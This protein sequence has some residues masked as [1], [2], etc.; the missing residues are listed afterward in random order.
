MAGFTIYGK[1]AGNYMI[2][3]VGNDDVKLA[4]SMQEDKSDP[5]AVITVAGLES[6]RDA[7]YDWI[8]V[9]ITYGIGTK[10]DEKDR[11]YMAFSFWLLNF[12]T[13]AVDYNMLMV[14]D[15]ASKGIEHAIRVLVATEDDYKGA[16]IYGM[17]EADL[18]R[19]E[20]VQTQGHYLYD[21]FINET[22]V[23]NRDV[24][25]LPKDGAVKYTVVIWLEGWDD[26]CIDDLWGSSIKMSLHITGR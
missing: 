21:D 17:P 18:S 13:R 3:V 9:D 19:K 6:Q 24:Y 23:M 12:S 11:N 7:T 22:T 14:I 10:N 26:Q 15:D 1:E 5:Q 2:E 25:N 16:W 20:Y 8:P 4:L